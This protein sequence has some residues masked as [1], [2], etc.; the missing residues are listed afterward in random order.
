MRLEARRYWL[1]LAACFVAVLA[2]LLVPGRATFLAL[3][4]VLPAV[5][6]LMC[7]RLHDAGRP[8]ALGLAPLPV[9]VIALGGFL[10]VVI[11]SLRAGSE[12]SPSPRWMDSAAIALLAIAGLATLV[13]PMLIGRL[14]SAPRSEAVS[15]EL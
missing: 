13:P 12:G 6:V 3:L 11:L 15:S 9:V 8:W 2:G 14:A 5:T 10:A 4:T 1:G 7:A